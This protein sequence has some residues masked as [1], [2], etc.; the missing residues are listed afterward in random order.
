MNYFMY[1]VTGLKDTV[2]GIGAIL[3]SWAFVIGIGLGLA[4]GLQ[5]F[6]QLFL[7]NA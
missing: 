1:L 4:Y 6:F 7:P 5:L 3:L 2:V